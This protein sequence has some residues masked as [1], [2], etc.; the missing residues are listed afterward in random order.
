MLA[1]KHIFTMYCLK[2][3]TEEGSVYDSVLLAEL[4]VTNHR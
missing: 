4:H 3:S 2:V 1:L